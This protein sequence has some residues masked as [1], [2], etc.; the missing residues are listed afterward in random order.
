MDRRPSC[1]EAQ[2]QALI[3]EGYLILADPAKA[4][5]FTVCSPDMRESFTVTISPLPDGCSC[6]G[7]RKWRRCAHI[8]AARWEQEREAAEVAAFE[9]EERLLADGEDSFFGCDWPEGPLS[10]GGCAW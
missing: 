2:A 10:I 7:S 9:E 1:L 5:F 4:G 6:R 3:E 8:L